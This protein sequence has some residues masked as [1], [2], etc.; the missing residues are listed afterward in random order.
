MVSWKITLIIKGSS[1]RLK[2]IR[3]GC[4]NKDNLLNGQVNRRRFKVI[5]QTKYYDL[6]V[7]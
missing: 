5:F 3:I 2:D 7:R 6:Q 4:F 1:S